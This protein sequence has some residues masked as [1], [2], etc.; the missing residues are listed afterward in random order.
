LL[1]EMESQGLIRRYAI[2]GGMAVMFYAEPV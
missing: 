2:G 1:N